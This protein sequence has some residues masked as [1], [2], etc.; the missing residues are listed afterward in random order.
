[1]TPTIQPYPTSPLGPEELAHNPRTSSAT[2]DRGRSVLKQAPPPYSPQTPRQTRMGAA[3]AF[4]ALAV[5]LASFVLLLL[6]TLSVPIIESIY[7]FKIYVDVDSLKDLIS[8]GEIRTGVFGYCST[9]IASVTVDALSLLGTQVV[10]PIGCTRRRL[11]YD[12]PNSLVDT[13]NEVPGIEISNIN[14]AVIRKLT[15]VLVLYP[16]ATG[17]TGGVLVCTFIAWFF[18]S[19]I[20]EIVAFL[21]SWLAA[22]VAWLAFFIAIA[23][24]TIAKRRIDNATDGALK[25]SLGNAIWMTLAA[26]ILLSFTICLTCCGMF[27]PYRKKARTDTNDRQRALQPIQATGRR[28]HFWNIAEKRQDMLDRQRTSAAEPTA[29]G[30]PVH[31]HQAIHP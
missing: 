29:P 17:L 16:I 8:T 4:P 27:G 9:G 6:V 11:G 24:F 28:R 13:L 20:A 5:T 25:G 14:G 21:I 23:A 31:P 2:Q 10:G 3:I 22:F 15:Y 18:R 1:M 30:A 26:A 7:L 12:I 19:R